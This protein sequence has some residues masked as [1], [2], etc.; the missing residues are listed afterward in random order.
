MKIQAGRRN[1]KH[2]RRKRLHYI[3]RTCGRVCR[4]TCTGT[5]RSEAARKPISLA[6]PDEYQTDF[7]VAQRNE[8]SSEINCPVALF[9]P[10]SISFLGQWSAGP[11]RYYVIYLR[12][13]FERQALVSSLSVFPIPG[14]TVPGA[15]SWYGYTCQPG[16]VLPS[17]PP[18]LLHISLQFLP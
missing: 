17:L 3:G 2:V 14:P 6:F 18:S 4:Y 9:S 16:L 13:I 5:G 1:G 10:N 8:A 15:G 12:R 11:A 7:I